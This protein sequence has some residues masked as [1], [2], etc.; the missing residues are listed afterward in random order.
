MIRSLNGKTPRIAK[1]AFVSEAAY[2]VGDVQIGENSGVW[3][4]AVI[5]ADFGT[6]KIGSNSQVEDNCVVHGSTDMEIGDWVLLGHGSVMHGV[7][8][9]KGALV[10]SNATIL[11]D[12]EIGDGCVIGAGSVVS[13]GMKIPPRSLVVGVPAKVKRELSEE[14]T[15]QLKNDSL[16]YSELARR[17]KQQGLEG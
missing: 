16:I 8:I 2:V 10:G 15:A 6:I 1:S 13:Q 11:D 17:H 9:G 7:K 14:Q 5:R 12:V 3:P 4:G